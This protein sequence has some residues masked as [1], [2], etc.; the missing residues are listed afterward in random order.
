MSVPKKKEEENH[1]ELTAH[2]GTEWRAV[3]KLRKAVLHSEG[4]GNEG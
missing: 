1:T 2:K 3:L 4:D